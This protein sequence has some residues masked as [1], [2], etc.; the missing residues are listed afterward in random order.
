MYSKKKTDSLNFL[1]KSVIK[2][3]NKI[4]KKYL[5]FYSKKLKINK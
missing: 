2:Y 3:N 4:Y 5:S 1:I